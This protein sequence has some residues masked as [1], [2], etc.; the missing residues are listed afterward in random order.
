[1]FDNSKTK[2][3][4]GIPPRSLSPLHQI[5]AGV[6]VRIRELCS[7]PEVSLRLREIGLC[8]G[9]IIRLIASHTNIICQV[10]NAR[11]ALNSALARMILVESF[12]D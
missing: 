10:C 4:T 8:E 5:K 1:M 12:S 7:T 11:L 9:Q 3:E 6:T 2:V